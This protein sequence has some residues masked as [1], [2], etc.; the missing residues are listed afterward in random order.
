MNFVSS[1]RTIHHAAPTVAPRARWPDYFIASRIPPGQGG[2]GTGMSGLDVSSTAV[3][4]Q[5]QA[6]YKCHRLSFRVPALRH[7]PPTCDR[8]GWG[9]WRWRWTSCDGSSRGGWR[10]R[11][12]S[13]RKIKHVAPLCQMV[14]LMG[15]VPPSR[16]A[17]TLVDGGS[18]VSGADKSLT[19]LP[20]GGIHRE[21]RA[22][23]FVGNAEDSRLRPLVPVAVLNSHRQSR[24][25]RIPPPPSYEKLLRK[26]PC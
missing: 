10:H 19:P 8:Q 6:A 18:H 13:L 7:S 24:I 1:K 26:W 12:C 16:L 4:M 9:P 20:R 3:G 25:L 2:R 15:M 23:G 14:I 22:S 21:T 5:S 17:A 11:P